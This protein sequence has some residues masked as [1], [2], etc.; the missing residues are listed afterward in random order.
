MSDSPQ[1]TACCPR[2]SE[3]FST[4]W[5]NAMPNLKGSPNELQWSPARRMSQ[6]KLVSRI[7]SNQR[8]HWKDQTS[9]WIGCSYNQLPTAKTLLYISTDPETI[10]KQHRDY[11]LCIYSC[12][13]RK[14]KLESGRIPRTNRNPNF[15]AKYL[16]IRHWS[17]SIV[18]SCLRTLQC[19]FPTSPTRFKW[20]IWRKWWDHSI[21]GKMDCFRVL[22]E[23][24]RHYRYFAR[25]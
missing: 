11:S 2:N 24:E 10:R 21:T 18:S 5:K 7:C 23:L 3:F 4:A 1:K 25:R 14:H 6:T 19:C 12:A 8:I 13:S 22:L 16:S 15:S 9:V 17:S 20:T